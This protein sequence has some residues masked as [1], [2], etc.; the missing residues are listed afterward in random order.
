[1]LGLRIAGVVRMLGIL[2]DL[3]GPVVRRGQIIRGTGGV[4]EEVGSQDGQRLTQ[5]HWRSM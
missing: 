5:R 4:F 1:M 2:V 3:L